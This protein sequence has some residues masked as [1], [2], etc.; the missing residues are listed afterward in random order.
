MAM[1]QPVTQPGTEPG[2]EP[3]TEPATHP[4]S[5][6]RDHS[7]H[8]LRVAR[9]VPETADASSFVLDVP[10]ELEDAFAYEAG[11]F[12]TFRVLVDEEPYV[13]CYSMCSSPELGEDLQVTVKRVPGGVV[14]NWMNDALSAGDVVDVAPPAGFFRLAT[15]TGDLVMLG[16]GSGITPIIS[17]VKTAL[18]TT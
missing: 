6:A 13:R 18:A 2:T 17:P 7:Y 3:A 9:V 8:P 16:A 10:T 4:A 11:Q 1:G 15:G 5:T 14:S 12:C